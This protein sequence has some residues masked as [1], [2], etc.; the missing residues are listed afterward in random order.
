MNF[1]NN[2]A[3]LES[4]G[5]RYFLRILVLFIFSAIFKSFDLS[6]LNSDG[7]GQHFRSFVFSFIY[8]LFGLFA[9]EGATWLTRAVE[10]RASSKSV[11]LRLL[12]LC[13]SLVLYGLLAAFLF[14]FLY[15]VSDIWLFHRYEAWESFRSLSYEMNFGIFLFYML[16]LAFSGIVVYYKRWKEY[17]VKSERLM[18]ENIQARYDVLMNQIEPHF[19]FNSLSVLTNLVYKSADLSAEYITRLAQC[20]RYILD[21]KFEN[22]ILI[23]SEMEFLESYIF[24]IRVRHQQSIIFEMDI[25]PAVKATKMIPPATLQMLVENAVKHNRFS[26]NEPLQIKIY[27]DNS[28]LIVMNNL[29]KRKNMANSTGLG[30][31][32][33]RKRYQLAAGM[34]IEITEKKEKFIVK[35]PVL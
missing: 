31:E 2:E 33:I 30:L 11:S 21:K 15:A 13:A 19:F 4:K 17:Q 34:D 27:D 14:G 8:V 25:S 29:N 1:Q 28:G 23:E 6:F 32:N 22:L 20:Y 24:L 9:W 18:R 16:M 7:Q 26:A 12:L 3:L 5:F 35:L 10:Q